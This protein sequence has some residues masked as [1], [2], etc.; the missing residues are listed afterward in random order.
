MLYIKHAD[1]CIFTHMHTPRV[2]YTHLENVSFQLTGP[3]VVI[4]ME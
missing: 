1:R 4:V 2:Y 3:L